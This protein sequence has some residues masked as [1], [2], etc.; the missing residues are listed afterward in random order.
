MPTA[1]NAKTMAKKKRKILTH[2]MTIISVVA[3]VLLWLSAASA[4]ISP[5]KVPVM[6]LIELAFPFFLIFC[7][8]T[9]AATLLMAPRRC[10]ICLVG[11]LLASS[12]I[13]NYFPLNFPSSPPDDALRIMSYNVYGWGNF[14]ERVMEDENGKRHNIL[15]QYVGK[16]NPDIAFLQEAISDDKFIEEHLFS[17]LKE[18]MY[19]DSVDM[20]FKDAPGCFNKAMLLSKFPIV[21]KHL[22]VRLHA[23]GAAAF[24]LVP[25]PGDTIIAINCHL[26]SMGLNKD[27]RNS[28]SEMVKDSEHQID[29]KTTKTL[30]SKIMLAGKY[31]AA[32]VDSIAAFI[33]K[34]KDKDIILGGDF[35]DT[36]VSYSHGQLTKHL[37]D[38]YRQSGNGLGRTFNKNAMIVR[39]D[40]V[41]CSDGFKAYGFEVDS[42]VGISDHNPVLGWIKRFEN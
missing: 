35:N 20:A 12:S 39:I 7:I 14:P 30:L 21:K 41:L 4:F 31:R 29:K 19:M 2:T 34:H 40:H 42:S 16:V 11:L 1:K 26:V 22:I 17:E 23:N 5:E 33:E 3:V 15:A 13:R 6:S 36:P 38:A 25:S 24:W 27:D 28:F 32:M 8:L 10:W 9:L 18:K 37:S